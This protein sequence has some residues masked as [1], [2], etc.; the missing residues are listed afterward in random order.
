MRLPH[1]SKFHIRTLWEYRLSG[2]Q[3]RLP[4]PAV[5]KAVD[6]DHE[7]RIAHR[8][9]GSGYRA[10]RRFDGDLASYNRIAHICFEFE[11]R[12]L[13]IDEATRL[14][15]SAGKDDYVRPI[16][17]RAQVCCDATSPV[18]GNLG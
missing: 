12:S 18:A 6:E 2:D 16:G 13:P 3:R 4:L 10:S 1:N 15:T 8:H 14:Q 17:L 5:A 7:V 9:S 11:R